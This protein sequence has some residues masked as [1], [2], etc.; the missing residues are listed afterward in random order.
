MEGK[1]TPL[2]GRVDIL[3]LLPREVKQSLTI[4]ETNALLFDEILPDSL[5]E[6]LKD[7]LEDE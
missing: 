1:K 2:P 3:K 5:Q 6:K 4:E 7:F